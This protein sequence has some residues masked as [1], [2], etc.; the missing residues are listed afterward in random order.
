M[1]LTGSALLHMSGFHDVHFPVFPKLTHLTI[2]MGG[3]SRVLHSL[4][5]SASKLQSLV[6]DL[7]YHTGPATVWEDLETACTPE[8][9]LS[10]LEVIEIKDLVWQEGDWNIIVH[11]VNTGVV[12][13]K[14]NIHLKS[15]DHEAWG[16]TALAVLLKQ[17]GGLRGREARLFLPNNKEIRISSDDEINNEV[18]KKEGGP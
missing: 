3:R 13:K 4:L 1:C 18:D 12:L 16:R 7:E 6:I 10:S 9:L 15:C 11:L 2:G 17:W 8:C 14:V 5:S